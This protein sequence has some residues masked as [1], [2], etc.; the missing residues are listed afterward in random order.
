MM[1]GKSVSVPFMPR[2]EKLDGTLAG[3]V[4]FGEC[5]RP[6]C[7][8]LS[9][10]RALSCLEMHLCRFKDVSYALRC[11]T[12]VVWFRW[13]PCAR[14]LHTRAY[15]H[16]SPFQFVQR[17]DPLGLSD[18]GIPLDFLREAEIKHGRI[19]MLA[20]AGWFLVDF[21]IHLPGDMHAV[22]LKHTDN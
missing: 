18:I 21:G 15:K 2:P 13:L 6:E 16:R 9:C 1:A 3:D 10:E 7:T 14:A 12:A 19:C 20:V 8:L 4:G 22:S 17:T 11:Y 5:M